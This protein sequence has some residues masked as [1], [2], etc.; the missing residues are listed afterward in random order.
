[1]AG[2]GWNPCGGNPA[3][4]A[5]KPDLP[6]LGPAGCGVL[7]CLFDYSQRWKNSPKIQHFFCGKPI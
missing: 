6:A 4:G 3:G 7:A 2:I 5:K 1:M